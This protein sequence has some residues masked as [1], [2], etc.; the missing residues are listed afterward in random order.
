MSTDAFMTLDTDISSDNISDCSVLEDAPPAPS[1][2]SSDTSLLPC[3]CGCGKTV[4]RATDW[5]HRKRLGVRTLAKGKQPA[6]KHTRSQS[7]SESSSNRPKRRRQNQSS[8]ARSDPQSHLDAYS[9][10]TSSAS[11]FESDI[12]GICSL[13]LTDPPPHALASATC[14]TPDHQSHSRPSSPVSQVDHPML[15]SRWVNTHGD[16]EL[17]DYSSGE[18]FEMDN[19]TSSMG[20][21]RQSDL[22]EDDE[23]WSVEEDLGEGF[24]REAASSG[25]YRMSLHHFSIRLTLSDAPRWTTSVRGR[26]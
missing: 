4:D 7:G 12:S 6:P 10:G 13:A 20:S 25:E 8:D 2:T 19:D 24:E 18:D 17:S 5:R 16:D 22:G 21:Q 11:L 9:P 3:S 15:V 23:C 1:I 26:S 14:G